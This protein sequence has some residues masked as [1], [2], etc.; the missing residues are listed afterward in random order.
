MT[1]GPWDSCGEKPAATPL[2]GLCGAARAPTADLGQPVGASLATQ[3][4]DPGRGP[5]RSRTRGR[6]W[7]PPVS[8]GIRG[9]CHLV[10]IASLSLDTNV[11]VG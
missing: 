11:F 4:A 8:S 1:F 6:R 9:E 10:F 5:T 3:Q 2:V 7:E